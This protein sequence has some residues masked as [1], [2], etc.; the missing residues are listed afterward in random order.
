MRID[1]AFIL[2]LTAQSDVICIMLKLYCAK[3]CNL[4]GV[5][6]VT[7]S[8]MP[9]KRISISVDTEVINALAD[10]ATELNMSISRMAETA[11]IEHAKALG[12]ISKNY[13]PLG[14]TRGGDRTTTG[15]EG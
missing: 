4:D 7:V 6:T 2:D 10:K 15:A 11:L 3:R 1:D 14:E 13:R 9:R 12:L 8:R 5:N